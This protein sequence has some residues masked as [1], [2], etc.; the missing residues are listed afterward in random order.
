MLVTAV[1]SAPKNLASGADGSGRAVDENPAPSTE[2]C[3]LQTHERIERSVADR[4]SLHEAHTGRH[5]LDSGARR[6]RDELSVCPEPE[7]SQ[8]EDV[9]TDR[10]VADGRADRP[11]LSGKLSAKDP[12]P[13]PPEAKDQAAEEIGDEAATP[14]GFASMDVRPGDRR[15][16]DLDEHLVLFGDGPLDVFESQNVRWPVPVVDNRFHESPLLPTFGWERRIGLL[17]F[18]IR[19]A[20]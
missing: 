14:V 10:E 12:L 19:P 13:R 15:R 11:D 2:I 18:H 9:V 1:T 20:R 5:V 3:L 4:C 17:Y 7:P 8:S 16:A 6:H